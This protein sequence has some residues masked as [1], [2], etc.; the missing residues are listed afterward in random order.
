[1]KKILS[2]SKLDIIIKAKKPNQFIGSMLRGALG[3]S[4][5]KVTCIN[6]SFTCKGCFATT[7]CL[8]YDFFETKNRYH[9]YR[10]DFALHSE[11]FE[12]SLYLYGDAKEKLPY[13][14]S[15][16]HKSLSENGLGKDRIKPKEFF[17]YINGRTAYD[18]KE[19]KIPQKYIKEFQL[20]SYSPN[21]E[22]QLLT[23]LRIKRESRFVGAK[24]FDLV[25]VL[26]SLYQRYLGLTEQKPSK[27]PFEPRYKIE[28]KDINWKQLTRYS[29]RQQTKMNMD[30]L[31]GEII[32]KDIDNQSYELL[33][34]GEI[35]GAGKQTVMG[36]GKIEVKDL[37]E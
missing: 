25:Y 21:I 7:N 11:L 36:L 26:N 23:P 22:L 34:L 5:K 20:D 13:L 6:P 2:Y 31:M 12:F 37:D 4:L 19:F 3:Y 30:G 29:N 35:I 16:L 24:E 9:N 32:I 33:K 18:G 28:K 10:F 1:M 15:A 8:Y 17:F 27:L 14:L